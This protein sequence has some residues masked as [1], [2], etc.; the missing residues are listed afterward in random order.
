MVE[1]C[2]YRMRLNFAKNTSVFTTSNHCF[3]DPARV[4]VAVRL[5][6]Y[7]DTGAGKE[8]WLKGRQRFSPWLVQD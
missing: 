6:T 1:G 2:D 7:S 8:D 4:R 3:G 5:S